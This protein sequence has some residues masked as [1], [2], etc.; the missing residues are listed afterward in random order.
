MDII[1]GIIWMIRYHEQDRIIGEFVHDMP[2]FRVQYQTLLWISQ[3]VGCFLFTV[4][5]VNT[6][7]SAQADQRIDTLYV[8]MTGARPRAGSVDVEYTLYPTWQ[9]V[10]EDSQMARFR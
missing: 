7:T 3:I 9:D 4:V 1:G 6:A 10:V 8:P 5:I 2:V